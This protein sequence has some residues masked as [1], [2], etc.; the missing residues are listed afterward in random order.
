MTVYAERRKKAL[1]LAKGSPVVAMTGAN[2]FYLTDFWGGGAAI[3]EPE[4]TVVVTTPLEADR[5]EELAHEAEVVTVKRWDDVARQVGRLSGRA[6]ALV[7]DDRQ[8]RADARFKLRPD[9]FQGARRVKD[10]AEIVRIA[11]ACKGLDSIFEEMPRLLKPGRTEWEV[12]A[13]VMKIATADELVPPSFDGALSPL[14]LA[15]GPN[16][17]LP[18]SDLTR[19]RLKS[20][21]MVVVDIFFRYLGYHSDATRTFA[22]GRPNAEAKKDYS[23]VLE[24]QLE[25]L[26][27][28]KTGARCGDV[29]QKVVSTLQKSGLAEYFIH[30]TGHGVG[31]DIHEEPGIRSGSETVLQEN[32]VVTDEPGIYKAGKYGIRIEDTVRVGSKPTVMTRYT[33]E[34]VTAG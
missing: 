11:R 3:V 28:V 31:I 10:E 1:A 25:S 33:K 17:A 21:D 13:D 26:R 2:M 12:A 9:V 22:V 15:S 27:L 14:I 18:H 5:A 32:E 20:G 16:G 23:A 6:E 24:S 30:S 7:D 4:K 19:R 8:L 29:H 34:L